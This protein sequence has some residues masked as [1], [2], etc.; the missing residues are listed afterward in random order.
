MVRNPLDTEEISHSLLERYG[1][2]IAE[3]SS[4]KWT[5]KSLYIYKKKEGKRERKKERKKERKQERK[6]ER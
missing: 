1:N 4:E 2:R 5:L 6:K 3:T